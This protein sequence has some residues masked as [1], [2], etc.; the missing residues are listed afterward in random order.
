MHWHAPVRALSIEIDL[1]SRYC[2]FGC[3]LI[4]FLGIVHISFIN[5]Y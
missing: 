5:Q 2:A 1:F 3:R 4:F